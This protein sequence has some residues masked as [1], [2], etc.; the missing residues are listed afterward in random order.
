[1]IDSY[2][3]TAIDLDIEGAALSDFPA[4]ERRATAIADLEQAARAA[5]RQLDVWLTLPVEPSGLQDNALSV[6]SAMLRDGG[7]RNRDQR[8]D[9]GLRPAPGRR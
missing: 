6:I 8:H 4:E 7:L 9:H 2:K 5:H 1:M 3:L